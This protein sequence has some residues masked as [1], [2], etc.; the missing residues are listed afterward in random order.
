MRFF[1]GFFWVGAA[2][3]FACGVVFLVF[4]WD[5]SAWF[6]YKDF[7]PVF[8]V[9]ATGLT[10]FLFGIGFAYMAERPSKASALVLLV[11]LF[12]LFLPVLAYLGTLRGELHRTVLWFHLFNDLLWLPFL[13]AF[14]V[15]FYH[16]PR[17]QR[18]LPLMGVF[19]SGFRRH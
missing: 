16:K 19:G 4:P 12:K 1:R 2:Y 15:W 6:G 8:L 9:Q 14:F 5:L 11:G 3:H 10:F 13:A 7:S 18:F 17:P